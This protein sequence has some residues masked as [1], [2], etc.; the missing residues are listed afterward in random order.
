MT[1]DN[2][3]SLALVDYTGDGDNELIAGSEDYDIRV[4]KEDEIISEMTEDTG[5]YII[6]LK[7]RNLLSYDACSPII[8]ALIR[9][10]LEYCDSISYKK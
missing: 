9:C 10:Q 8:N 6:D 7:I 3:C 5:I 1:G 4:F 2:V